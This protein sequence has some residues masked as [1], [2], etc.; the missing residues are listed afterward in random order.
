[1]ISDMERIKQSKN[2]AGTFTSVRSRITNDNT[3]KTR[4]VQAR[5]E[6]SLLVERKAWKATRPVDPVLKARVAQALMSVSLHARQ[7]YDLL[8]EDG[9]D[10]EL[11]MTKDGVLLHLDQSGRKLV[12][13]LRS[14]PE[15]SGVHGLPLDVS[16][17]VYSI[18]SYSAVENADISSQSAPDRT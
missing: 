6:L 10:T 8:M 2:L 17:V 1:M 4:Q 5:M 3:A 14:E 9:G 15:L 7:L 16:R 13:V 11:H 18:P 12:P